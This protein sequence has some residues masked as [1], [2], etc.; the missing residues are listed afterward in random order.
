MPPRGRRLDLSA[1]NACLVTGATG[2]IGGHI[3]Q[4]L[5]DDGHQVRCLVRSTSDT[6]LLESMPVEIAVGD[7][8]DAGSL[9]RA[10][11]GC[12]Y[13]VHCGAQVSDWATT[14]QMIQTN[15]TGTR[16]LLRAAAEASAERFVH[17]SST[18]VYGYPA[19]EVD[20]S[21]IASGFA[22]WYSETKRDGESEVRRAQEQGRS[23]R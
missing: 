12:R 7:L 17:I 20:E 21:H 8:T 13:V 5:L 6:A 18:D 4:R 22:N 10:A 11:E 16:N 3:A 15:V 23:R 14:E 9:Q 1:D 19:R 2:F